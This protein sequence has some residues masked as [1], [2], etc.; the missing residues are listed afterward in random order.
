MLIQIIDLMK[1]FTT[2]RGV[3][4]RALEQVT[5]DVH[6]NEMICILGRSGCGKS[7]LLRIIAGLDS[8]SKGTVLMEGKPISGPNPER[9]MVFQDSRL[10]MWRT[11]QKNIEFGLEL[12]GMSPEERRTRSQKYMDMMGL[13]QFCNSCSYELSGGM[14]QRVAIARMLINE[15]SVM[16][17]DE[18]FGALD[19]L[20]R[21]KLQEELLRLME[22]ER[23]TTLFVTHSVDEAIYLGDKIVV[24]SERPGTVKCVYEPQ[25]P[26]PRDRLSAE[27]VNLKQEIMALL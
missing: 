8:P 16:L 12:K 17:M 22:A 10:F 6:K 21:N 26:K 11:V 23:R 20:T 18:P 4:V 1:E 3:C 25:I 13:S 9:G 27:V 2:E 19:A 7:T 24:L 5:F 14:R 15:P